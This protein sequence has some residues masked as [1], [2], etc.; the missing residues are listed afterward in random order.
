MKVDLAVPDI[1]CASCTNTI[2][3]TIKS[4]WPW[5]EVI[6]DL[7]AKKVSVLVSDKRSIDITS[8]INELETIGFSAS[9]LNQAEIDHYNKQKSI[10]NARKKHLFKALL[11]LPLGLGMVLLQALG[12]SF[13]IPVMVV[14]GGV[15]TTLCLFAGFEMYQTSW[16]KFYKNR[17]L[18]METLFTL[19]TIL[20][21]AVSVGA[22]FV[23]FFAFEF[24]AAL[25]IL[26]VRHL[27]QYLESGL[28]ARFLNTTGFSARLPQ[29]VNKYEAIS[30]DLPLGRT[31]S[32]AQK[33]IQIGDLI[34]VYEGELIPF[35][36][37][38]IAQASIISTFHDGD[39]LPFTAQKGEKVYAGMRVDGGVLRLKVTAL[40]KDCYAAKL[41][42]Q[43][44]RLQR[45]KAMVERYADK[46]IRYFIPVLLIITALTTIAV[47]PFFGAVTAFN[48][49]LSM[50][51]G[52]CPCTLGF[53][54]PFAMRMGASR[55]AE[56]GI[57]A[58]SSRAIEKS[59]AINTVI[60]DLN[61]TLTAGKP[62]ISQYEIFKGTKEQLFALLYAMEKSLS[63]QELNSIG[64]T[65]L[66]YTRPYEDKTL[67][68]QLLPN[69]YGSGLS[70]KFD[71]ED[72]HFGNRDYIKALGLA[73]LKLKGD[74]HHLF[75]FKGAECLMR[76]VINDP[77][78]S[79]ALA[80]VN[81]LKQQGKEIFICTGADTKT[82]L[83][84]GEHLRLRQDHIYANVC[85][86]EA[87][88]QVIENLE[89]Q[90]GLSAMVGDAGND[91]LAISAA[92]I[93]IAIRG[94]DE[95]SEANADLSIRENTLKPLV[96]LFA[97]SQFTMRII[98]QSL[99]TSLTYNG[100]SLLATT[101]VAVSLGP[102]SPAI[103]ASLMAVQSMLI[104]ANAYRIR[105]K[106]LGDSHMSIAPASKTENKLCPPRATLDCNQELNTTINYQPQLEEGKGQ[107]QCTTVFKY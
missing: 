44:E 24:Q 28:K 105:R 26:G 40:Q 96:P 2:T 53:I 97:I 38:V 63:A 103:F 91:A 19:S 42:K 100:L 66:N 82:A 13:S 92:Y 27:G 106:D 7:M 15:S 39:K 46:A 67:F 22:F 1:Q 75:L 18:S 41:D 5:L 49:A 54:I 25:M 72:Y 95:I 9:V 70:A 59:S 87:K 77:L 64:K 47:L 34:E 107:P 51:V 102:L 20:A 89:A 98:K 30:D 52:A 43:L 62:K 83:G 73:S 17:H 37:K 78:K 32:C 71:G 36:G 81:A 65:V 74:K 50:L 94:G 88:K 57:R 69:A 31:V 29:Q 61:G 104:L 33:D 4:Q 79:D 21:L 55:L 60:F 85:G 14:F 48:T 84:Y 99:I 35:D 101:M 8:I 80:T 86:V 68:V 11:L 58:H 12:V 6:P 45:Q 93:G 76:L 23:P 3:Q 10:Q 16:R 56:A 90:R